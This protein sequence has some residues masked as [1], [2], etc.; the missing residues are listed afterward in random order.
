MKA[1]DNP[2]L[3]YHDPL[4]QYHNPLLQYHIP[5]PTDQIRTNGATAMCAASAAPSP[6]KHSIT[7]RAAAA[8]R[9]QCVLH[10]PT[11]HQQH[12]ASKRGDV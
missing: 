8:A 2:L 12:A 9:Q 10:C 3:Q 5:V 1:C 4:L 11:Q 7:A 6:N